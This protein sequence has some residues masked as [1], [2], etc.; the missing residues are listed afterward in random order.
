MARNVRMALF[1]LLASTLTRLKFTLHT[2]RKE[3]L[4]VFSFVCSVAEYEAFYLIYLNCS[5]LCDNC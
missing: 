3:F 2:C 5:G 1:Q 4:T